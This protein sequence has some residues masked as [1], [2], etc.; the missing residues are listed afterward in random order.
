MEDIIRCQQTGPSAKNA[1]RQL[2]L[3][4]VRVG[5]RLGDDP[6]DSSW[7]GSIWNLG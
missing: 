1:L 6:A 2:L 7:R 4:G 5:S 3:R